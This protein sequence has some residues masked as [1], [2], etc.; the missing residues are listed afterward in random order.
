MS[1]AIYIQ[2]QKI[3]VMKLI[4]CDQPL[5]EQKEILERTLEYWMGWNHQTD[6]ILII[7]VRV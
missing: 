5:Y 6:D 4:I 3:K 7:G 1:T 2:V